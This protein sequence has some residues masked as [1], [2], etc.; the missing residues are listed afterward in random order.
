MGDVIQNTIPKV[1]TAPLSVTIWNA[2]VYQTLAGRSFT[3]AAD[4]WFER[5]YKLINAKKEKKGRNM[6]FSQ[7]AKV[8]LF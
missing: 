8:C 5:D 3:E 7:V 2:D 6:I 1:H 4:V